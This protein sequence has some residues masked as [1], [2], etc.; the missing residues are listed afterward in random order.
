MALGSLEESREGRCKEPMV[1]GGD[2]YEAP[3]EGPNGQRVAGT[4]HVVGVVKTS[5]L[6]TEEAARLQMADDYRL[7]DQRV[8]VNATR[9]PQSASRP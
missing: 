8:Q 5:H 4:L 2:A 1:E 3:L 7:R 9:R 6:E